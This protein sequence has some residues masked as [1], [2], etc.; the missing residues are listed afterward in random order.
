MPEKEQSVLTILENFQRPECQYGYMLGE[1]ED[2]F[3]HRNTNFIMRSLFSSIEDGFSLLTMRA[4]TIL[5]SK[6]NHNKDD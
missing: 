3:S 6:S 2:S 1:G 5:N 4:V